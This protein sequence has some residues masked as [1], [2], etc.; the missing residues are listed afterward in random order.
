MS[1][2]QDIAKCYQRLLAAIVR[3]AIKDKAIWF[4]E[5]PEVK[6]YCA[7]VGFDTVKLMGR[8]A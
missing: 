5:R 3:Q 7:A 4:L 8:M 2:K 1:E 6:N